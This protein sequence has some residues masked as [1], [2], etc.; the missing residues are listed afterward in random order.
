MADLNISPFILQIYVFSKYLGTAIL[1]YDN[2]YKIDSENVLL[3]NVLKI[4]L[5]PA[6]GDNF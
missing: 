2:F 4:F 5:C 3:V 6:P 1:L